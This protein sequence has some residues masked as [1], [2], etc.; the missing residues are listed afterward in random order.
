MPGP[1][2]PPTDD[3]SFQRSLVNLSAALERRDKVVV[4]PSSAAS[5]QVEDM[6]ELTE[7]VMLRRSRNRR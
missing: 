5:R 3:L 2:E 7:K 6:K 1:T 4:E